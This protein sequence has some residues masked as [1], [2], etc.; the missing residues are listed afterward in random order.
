MTSQQYFANISVQISL[1][2]KE[3]D[4]FKIYTKR[5]VEKCPR[6]NFQTLRKPRNSKNKSGNRFAG[7]PVV[8]GKIWY[9]GFILAQTT[10][11]LSFDLHPLSLLNSPTHP[12]WF[13]HSS[14]DPFEIIGM[15]LSQLSPTLVPTTLSCEYGTNIFCDPIFFLPNIF[16][17][18]GLGQSLKLKLFSNI[19]LHH[20]PPPPHKLCEGWLI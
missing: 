13:C 2:N 18:L 9:L 20:Q 15:S 8:E 1:N 11:T 7:H 10:R 19:T 3:L 14:L 12:S 6:W 16:V 4:I 5:A 17:Q